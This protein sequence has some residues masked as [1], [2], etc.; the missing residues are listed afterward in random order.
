MVSQVHQAEEAP[1]EEATQRCLEAARMQEAFNDLEQ[2][3]FEANRVVGAMP[4]CMQESR[5]RLTALQADL[6]TE[7]RYVH[8]PD[9]EL[10]PGR[11]ISRKGTWLKTS[12]RFSWELGPEEKLYVPEGVAVPVLQ[13]GRVND[14]AELKLHEW[15]SQ[16]SVVWLKPALLAAIE[17]RR[18]VWFVYWPHFEDG[19]QLGFEGGEGFGLCCTSDTWLKRTT[20]MSGELQPFEL[21]YVPTGTMLTLAKPAEL[22]EEAWEKN[23]H[24]H[25]HQ[26]RKVTLLGEPV[27]IR[28]DK[29]DILTGQSAKPKCF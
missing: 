21:L 15:S 8:G 14:V 23:R 25:V 17:A 29:Y 4:S 28:R 13:I 16:H 2:L 24:A 6:H 26:H 9:W 20:Q 5:D 27:T 1:D 3:L 22:V 11:L 18:H 19:A 10:K 7:M 12:T